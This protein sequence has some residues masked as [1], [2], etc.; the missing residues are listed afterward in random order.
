MSPGQV[1]SI[2]QDVGFRVEADL[3]L[4]NAQVIDSH[5]WWQKR[6]NAC[7]NWDAWC[8]ETVTGRDYGTRKPYFNGFVVC[9]FRLGRANAQIA[10]L[11]LRNN[12]AVLS[13]SKNGPLTLVTV[14]NELD[15]N[16]WVEGWSYETKPLGG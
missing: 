9:T 1:E 4:T 14:V 12:K 15:A 16:D 7:G 13:W 10:E 3:G 5:S 2:V 8:W 11:A 6:F